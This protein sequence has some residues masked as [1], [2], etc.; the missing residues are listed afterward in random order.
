MPPAMMSSS[1]APA[2][3]TASP[4]IIETVPRTT[5]LSGRFVQCHEREEQ[6]QVQDRREDHMSG[7]SPRWSDGVGRATGQEGGPE[8]QGPDQVALACHARECRH[9]RDTPQREATRDHQPF[10]AVAFGIYHR[11]YL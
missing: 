1:V 9:E 8:Q 5:L 11:Q 7:R 2:V 10:G 3:T 6:R 4:W